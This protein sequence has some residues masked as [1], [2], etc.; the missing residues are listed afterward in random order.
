VE[1]VAD[2]IISHLT[3]ILPKA[4]ER[5]CLEA[6][7]NINFKKHPNKLTWISLEGVIGT[8]KT[9]QL[10][11][12]KPYLKDD[13]SI[14][15]INEPVEVWREQGWLQ[16]FYAGEID[17][18]EFQRLILLTFEEVMM[19]EIYLHPRAKIIITDRSPWTSREI[20]GRLTLCDPKNN[21][22][23]ENSDWNKY[24]KIF[25][26][27]INRMPFAIRKLHFIFLDLPPTQAQN[28][29]SARGREEEKKVSLD[30][31]N[32]L[33]MMHWKLRER[34]P[35]LEDE[36]G[37]FPIEWHRVCGKGTPVDTARRLRK[38]LDRMDVLPN[39]LSEADGE[40]LDVCTVSSAI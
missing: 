29:V 30:Y 14:V 5:Y 12:L 8:G 40:E 4:Q 23:D 24:N 39:R 1:I 22:D 19:K 33:R 21:Y 34:L 3:G 17:C 27:T 37:G 26:S 7:G 16:A 28:R 6:K 35:T 31:Q 38:Q 20:F 13:P 18:L 2:L 9:T 32:A 25:F 11:L 10:E 15:L 36:W